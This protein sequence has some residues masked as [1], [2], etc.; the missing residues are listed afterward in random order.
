MTELVALLPIA[1]IF[2]HVATYYW[3]RRRGFDACGEIEEIHRRAR[4][5]AAAREARE[6]TPT[7]GNADG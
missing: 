2:S 7:G 4:A 3:G 5:L 6:A 1:L